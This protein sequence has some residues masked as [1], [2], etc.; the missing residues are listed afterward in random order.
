[1]FGIPCIL[2]GSKQVLSKSSPASVP[3]SKHTAITGAG[4]PFN[5]SEQHRYSK[6]KSIYAHLVI[7]VIWDTK[8][9]LFVCV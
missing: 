6:G 8:S 4:A 7:M 5:I 9:F 3:F 2:T 1:M